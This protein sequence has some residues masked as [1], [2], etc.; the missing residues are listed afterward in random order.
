MSKIVSLLA[1]MAFAVLLAVLAAQSEAGA[2][3]E[4][5][6][7]P[8]L[9]VSN[10]Y[11]HTTA[12]DPMFHFGEPG[13]GHLHDFFCNTSTDASSTYDSLV[14]APD[15]TC[16]QEGDKSAYW[17]PV[18]ADLNNGV[19]ERL[20][21]VGKMIGYYE[22]T[23]GLPQR[24]IKTFAPGFRL[25]SRD[26]MAGPGRV[27]YKCP[28]RAFRSSPPG[29][30]DKEALDVRYIAPSCWDGKT[31][32]PAAYNVVKARATACPKTHPVN[33]PRVFMTVR[34]RMPDPN[35]TLRV[36]AGEGAWEA[37][38]FDHFNML[39]AWDQPTQEYKTRDCLIS[40]QQGER[41][42]EHCRTSIVGES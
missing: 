24:N 41:R 17:A 36:S 14:L 23:P 11:S 30:C 28:G 12:D 27:L 19:Y 38:G 6:Y 37:Y 20:E 7:G 3:K 5:Q 29:R 2:A 21:P 39:N 16:K 13:V 9:A 34:Y 18:H 15:D 31:D 8:R 4:A 42:P 25:V 22:V 32:A 35:L 33:V 26:G 40:T 10:Y 1:S